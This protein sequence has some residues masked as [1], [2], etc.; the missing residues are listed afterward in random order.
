[1]AVEEACDTPLPPAAPDVD[2]DVEVVVPLVVVD[3]PVVVEEES[4]VVVVE[5]DAVSRSEVGPRRT[6]Q[7]WPELH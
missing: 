1:M 3:V 5:E 2:V 7:T 6:P 4:L